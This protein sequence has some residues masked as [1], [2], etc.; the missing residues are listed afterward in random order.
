MGKG[1][2]PRNHGFCCTPACLSPGV[3]VPQR[4]SGRWGSDQREGKGRAQCRRL[5][6]RGT[7]RGHARRS[8]RLR[9]LQRL[10]SADTEPSALVDW[11]AT[12]TSHGLVGVVPLASFSLNNSHSP[13]SQGNP[14]HSERCKLRLTHALE[15]YV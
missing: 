13:N 9:G 5:G 1:C 10:G 4:D 3:R 7:L 8:G 15:L 12:G 11:A 14:L 6:W 2:C